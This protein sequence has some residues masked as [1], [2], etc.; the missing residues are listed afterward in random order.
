MIN[1]RVFLIQVSMPENKFLC[2]SLAEKRITFETRAAG[3]TSFDA[4]T[5]VLRPNRTEVLLN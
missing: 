3:C 1:L 2:P 5:Q 4:R